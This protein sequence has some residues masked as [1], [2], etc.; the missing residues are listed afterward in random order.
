MSRTVKTWA[1]IPVIA[2]AMDMNGV[3]VSNLI[4]FYRVVRWFS[5]G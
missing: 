3:L 2:W 1:Y 4:G 5:R